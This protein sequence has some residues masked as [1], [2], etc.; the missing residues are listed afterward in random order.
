MVERLNEFCGKGGF[1]EIQFYYFSTIAK[2]L[3]LS[4]LQ[5][6]ATRR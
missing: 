1:N 4:L 2:W 3:H 6:L 5:N